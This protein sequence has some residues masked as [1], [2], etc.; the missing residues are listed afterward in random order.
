MRRESPACCFIWAGSGPFIASLS[1]P[2]RCG[3]AGLE[4]GVR[5]LAEDPVRC[6]LMTAPGVGAVVALTFRATVNDPTRLPSWKK[7][8]PWVGL[9]FLAQPIRGARRDRRGRSGRRRRPPTSPVPSGHGHHEPGPRLVAEK[10]GCA[11]GEAPGPKA[12]NGRPGAAHR[13]RPAPHV[14]GRHGA[15]R[16][17][18]G[19]RTSV[20]DRLMGLAEP[21]ATV[22]ALE[23]GSMR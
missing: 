23:Q 1:R 12:R 10:L 16:S 2:K 8:R 7:V 4:R 15:S 21:H 3:L 13:P 5:L 17:R 14:E 20:A 6:R 22:L 19:E 11:G 9:N 18:S